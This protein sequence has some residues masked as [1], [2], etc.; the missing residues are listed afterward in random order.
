MI[1][2][3]IADMK[4]KKILKKYILRDPAMAITNSTKRITYIIGSMGKGGAERVI[5][6]LAN[7]YASKG[8][9]VDILMLLDD[10]CEYDL[11]N[12]IELIPIVNKE[13]AR[14][15]QL[16]K[17]LLSI[18]RYVKVNKPDRI[19]SFVARINLITIIACIGLNQRIIISE[20]NDPAADGRSMF[21]KYSTYLLYPYSK[22]I[23]FQT[24]WAQSCFP[25]EIQKKSIVIPNPIKVTVEAL[26]NK[27]KKI[28]SVGRLSE[29]K[30]HEMLI[31]AFFKI[32]KMHPEYRLYIYG[33]GNLRDSLTRQI[34][35]LNLDDKVF[36]PGTVSNIHEMIAD[37]EIFVLSSD[38][39]GLSN[40]LLE[41]MM[42][43]L[44]CI[45]TDCA[46][47]N[48]VIEDEKNGL[49]VPVGN[50]EKLTEAINRLI[51]NKEFAAELGKGAKASSV[52]FNCENVIRKWEMVI[53]DG[54]Q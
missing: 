29:Q 14:L 4:D 10:K 9:K 44:P 39:E 42:M 6:I 15:L 38:Y 37:A 50:T 2:N 31:N 7:R 36:L 34:H 33:E 32:Y 28:V 12:G 21:V 22:A 16:P 49:L 1:C 35:N 18:R 46:G 30:N 25:K 51:N 8:W 23:V 11:K 41:A 26:M 48:E 27:Q 43:G 53:E 20:R 40:A 52:I 5:S 17:W 3:K 54:I 24:K 45:S 13:R 19:V 47:S